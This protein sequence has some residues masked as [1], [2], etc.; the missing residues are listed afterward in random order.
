VKTW[1]NLRAS[2]ETDFASNYPI[3]VACAWVGNSV[4]VAMKHYLQVP[5]K[6]FEQASGGA[7]SG[8]VTDTGKCRKD[9]E[10]GTAKNA[11]FSDESAQPKYP[12]GESNHPELS[13]DLQRI[14]CALQLAL[15][16]AKRSL[17]E[18]G[19]SSIHKLRGAVT[20][21]SSRKAGGE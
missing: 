8:A 18:H 5:D 6:F 10:R 14:H 16:G 11:G 21:A 19:E 9:T 17:S 20:V 1:Q 7:A 15:H 4:G 12:Q 3:H 2:C 13:R